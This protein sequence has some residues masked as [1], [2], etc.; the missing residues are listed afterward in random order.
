M[1]MMSTQTSGA[2]PSRPLAGEGAFWI[3]RVTDAT[4]ERL[5][6]SVA[7]TRMRMSLLLSLELSSR[8]I[9]R[10]FPEAGCHVAPPSVLTVT[11]VML[12]PAT[13]LAVP[14][15]HVLP[16]TLAPGRGSVMIIVGES[17]ERFETTVMLNA[18]VALL[19]E[20]DTRARTGWTPF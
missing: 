15:S 17:S 18:W 3:L 19:L 6:L 16:L 1:T 2:R 13:E 11:A 20:S 5:A 10:V 12:A 4:V 8:N 7:R 9:Q 14:L